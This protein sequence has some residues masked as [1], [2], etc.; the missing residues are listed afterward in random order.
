MSRSAYATEHF[1]HEHLK[2]SITRGLEVISNTHF[3]TVYW[4]GKSVQRGLPAFQV[5]VENE[6]LG[7]DIA[8]LNDLFIPGGVRMKFELDLARLL[9]VIGPYAKVIQ[10]LEGGHVTADRVYY[11]WLGITSQLDSLFRRNEYDLTT[12]TIEDIRAITNC[13]FDEMITDAPND[14]YI[15]VF[16]LNPEYRNAPIYKKPNPLAI[17]P[18]RIRQQDGVTTTSLKLPEDIIKHVGLSLQRILQNKYGDTYKNTATK[19]TTQTVM[20]HHNPLLTNIHP[21]D[22]LKSLK[23]QLKSYGK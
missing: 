13:H 2:I 21:T 7:I 19:N 4:A 1:N 9:T 8:S 10:C 22:A 12:S 14:I 17:P 6:A 3:R 23:E 18:L 11:Y 15:I 20:E 16:F 5:I